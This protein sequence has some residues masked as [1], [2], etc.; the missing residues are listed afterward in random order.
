MIAISSFK[1]HSKPGE[2]R[3]N[4]IRAKESWNNLFKGVIYMNDHEP[5]LARS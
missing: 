2:H 4:Q 5:E 3:L 1:P